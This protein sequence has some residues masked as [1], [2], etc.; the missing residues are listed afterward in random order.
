M[1]GLTPQDMTA[2][3]RYALRQL[4]EEL[5]PSHADCETRIMETIQRTLSVTVNWYEL[6]LQECPELLKRDRDRID[7][8]VEL[9]NGFQAV[10]DHFLNKGE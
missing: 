3:Y 10:R 6:F 1:Q 4:S 5:D 9:G 2:Q 7:R 8:I